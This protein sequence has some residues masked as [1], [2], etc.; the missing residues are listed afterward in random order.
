[1]PVPMQV[2]MPYNFPM[3]TNR[4]LQIRLQ[5][6]QQMNAPSNAPSESNGQTIAELQAANKRR[7]S[8]PELKRDI[9]ALIELVHTLSHINPEVNAF[10]SQLINQ[11]EVLSQLDWLSPAEPSNLVRT[12]YLAPS[13]RGLIGGA[14][15]HEQQQQ[16]Q[17]QAP[18]NRQGLGQQNLTRL[19]RESEMSSTSSSSTPPAGAGGAQQ[20]SEG[21]SQSPRKRNRNRKKR[22][23]K[24]SPRSLKTELEAMRG[25]INRI[26]QQH[27]G[28]EQLLPPELIFKGDF[29]DLEEHARRLVAAGYGRIVEDEIRVNRKNNRQAFIT[30]STDREALD[31]DGIVLLPVAR[32]YAFEGDTVRAFVLNC[33]AAVTKTSE[34]AADNIIG[35]KG[36][37]S[38]GE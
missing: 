10:A 19:R 35:G 13:L 5:Q 8:R 17:Q 21:G 12:A 1:M 34:S 2:S 4:Q 27:V 16:Q 7:K 9:Q 20:Q 36:S 23:D 11:N 28:T 24:N 6:G 22:Q 38:L 15:K 14:Q 30:M 18:S 37:L 25:Y 29:D 26:V 33:G 31:R 3:Q 32:R